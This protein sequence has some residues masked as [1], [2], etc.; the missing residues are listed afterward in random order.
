MMKLWIALLIMV[1]ASYAHAA[2]DAVPASWALG[3]PVDP[4]ILTAPSTKSG[5]GDSYYDSISA[6]K[7]MLK[8]GEKI[9]PYNDIHGYNGQA[10]GTSGYALIRSGC[11]LWTFFDTAI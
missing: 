8:P 2:C 5:P 10:G 1:T 7:K 4:S 6:L 9:V 11:V 3:A